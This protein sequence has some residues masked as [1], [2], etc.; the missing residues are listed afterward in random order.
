MNNDGGTR[1]F[2][3]MIGDWILGVLE[4][5]VSFSVDGAQLRNWP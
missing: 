5:K 4:A 3:T 2:L 1:W